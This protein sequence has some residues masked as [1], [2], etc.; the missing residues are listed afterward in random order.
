MSLKIYPTPATGSVTSVSVTT[1]NG[2]SGSVATAT[3]TPAI[4]LTLGAITPT[5][6]GLAAAP[7]SDDTYQ[8]TIVT[9]L[10]NSG[11]VTQWNA[12][13]L[14]SSSQWVKADANGSSTYPALGV[15]VATALTTVAVTVLTNGLFRDDGQT[16]T[17]GGLLYLSET[18]GSITQTAPVT[19]ASIVQIVG[20]ALS[21]HVAVIAPD[22]TYITLA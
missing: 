10:V 17:P 13:Y 19:A 14:N 22:L 15:A 1:A 18:A 20:Y 9:G 11:G 16:W 7:G 2:V 3:T 5:S 6:I 12:V 8:G 21:A 4:T